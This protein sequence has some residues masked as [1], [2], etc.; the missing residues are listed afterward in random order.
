MNPLTS[1]PT[2]IGSYD[3][4]AVIG[5]G[6]MGTVFKAT[7][8]RIGRAVAIK[9]LTAAAD[10][11]D[12][13]DRFY[14]EA[15][16]TGNLQHQ[17]I[18]TVYELGHQ[19]GVP[20]LVMEYLEGVSLDVLIAS[21]RP[22]HI[23]EKLRIILQVCS[24][25]SYAHKRDLIHRDV[26]PANIVI[27]ENGTAKLVDFGIARLGGNRLT[28]TGQIVG[29]LNYMSPEQLDANTEVD[30]QTDVYSTG[31]V[32]Y[33]L[34]TGMLPFEGG[35]TA[36]TLMKIIHD[37]PPPI[38][39]YL[40]DCP[41]ELEA[42]TQKALAKNRQD[43]Y[44]SADD[45]ALD[46][47]RLQQRFEKQWLNEHCQ[48]AADSLERKDFAGAR[49]HV[50]QVL[51]AAPQN[52]EGGDLLRLIKKGEEQQQRQRQAEQLRRDA[53]AAFRRNDLSGAGQL[54]DQGLRL[55]PANTALASL[56]QGIEEARARADKCQAAL[57]RAEAALKL[58][59]L[60][61][62]S[63]S[64]EEAMTILPDDP[65]CKT[66][67]VQIAARIEERLRELEAARQQKLREEE[68]ARKQKALE[69]EAARK[70]REFALAVNA[71]ERVMADARMLLFLGRAQESLE[72]LE[73]IESGVSQLP[74]RWKEQF[75][76]LRK[77]ARAKLDENE[78]TVPSDWSQVPDSLTAEL[79]GPVNATVLMQPSPVRSEDR[80]KNPVQ[81]SD[82]SG[83]YT[84]TPA[85]P[86]SPGLAGRDETVIAPEL[87]E[88]LEPV[89]NGWLRPVISIGIAAAI[90]AVVVSLVIL[91]LRP[92]PSAGRSSA[93]AT[94]A[95][96]NAEPWGTIK[97]IV[98]ANGEARSAIG[99]TTPL[100]IT[101]PAGQYTLT[102]EGPN[103]ETKQVTLTVPT[104][105]GAASLVLFRKPDIKKLVSEE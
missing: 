105:G 41:A 39:K 55:D 96:I 19:D 18:V 88:F 102:L 50:L 13:L 24:G 52:T 8:P 51:R 42:I 14:R 84:S 1:K 4:V 92:K 2:H 34:M 87:M 62:A 7:D 53:E 38:R 3:I 80:N 90:L 66:L 36:A 22:M 23:A 43:R 54:V 26:K 28:R 93:R 83:P 9:V 63:H 57:R 97:D 81:E 35:S 31:V 11:P 94:Y 70:Q 5:R 76:A 58:D 45:F 29:S 101:L 48:R 60:Q 77:E 89:P 6:G 75:E 16:Y 78:R 74:P 12:L 27:L 49:Q 25:L 99:S 61:A 21:G 91:W 95:E 30:L 86:L 65:A 56:K 37:P 98:P 47:G 67:A 10:D 59:N 103:H 15:K 46:I 72:A 44:A 40:K 69:E 68:A 64:I 79:T 20:Y 104:Q 71:I 85:P 73:K 82:F 17:N 100:R 32:L 33:Q